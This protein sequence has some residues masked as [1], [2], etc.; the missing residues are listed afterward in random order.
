MNPDPHHALLLQCVAALLVFGL[1]ALLLRSIDLAS[2]PEHA[3]RPRQPSILTQLQQRPLPGVLSP[4]LPATTTPAPPAE[5]L[6]EWLSVPTDPDAPSALD[7]PEAVPAPPLGPWVPGPRT[8]G[9]G[10]RSVS[11]ASPDTEPVEVVAGP[12]SR[13]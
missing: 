1:E 13:G 9:A 11:P 6:D 10:W 3:D 7:E 4:L 12:G 5:W 8:A 2:E